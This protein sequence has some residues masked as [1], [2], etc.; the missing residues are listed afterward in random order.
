VTDALVVLSTVGKE[1]DGLRIARALVEAGL[2]ACVN[3]VPGLRSVYRWQG[4]VEEEGELLL[5]I[6]TRRDRFPA[7]REKLVELHPYEVPE[8][9]AVSVEDGHPPYLAWLAE[10]VGDPQRA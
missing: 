8:A 5:V 9:I 2:A 7:L 4:K 3:M 6:K 1:E 10:S